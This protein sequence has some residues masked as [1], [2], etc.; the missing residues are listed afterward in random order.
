[1]TQY[2]RERVNENSGR[3]R[4]LL[5]QQKNETTGKRDRVLVATGMGDDSK[6][7]LSREMTPEAM[8]ARKSVENYGILP[9]RIPKN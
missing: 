5:S 8:I 6:L 3:N 2:C 4:M 7:V 1:M 9:Q